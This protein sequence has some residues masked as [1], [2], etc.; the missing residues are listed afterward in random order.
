MMVTNNVQTFLIMQK[1]LSGHANTYATS[2]LLKD[3]CM[4]HA[5]VNLKESTE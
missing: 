2:P 3:V 5:E 1:L 4:Y